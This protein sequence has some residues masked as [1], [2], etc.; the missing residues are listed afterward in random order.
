[1]ALIGD[2]KHILRKTVTKGQ[3]FQEGKP[4]VWNGGIKFSAT[5]HVQENE[6][7]L[8]MMWKSTRQILLCMWSTW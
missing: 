3:K 8:E 4:G 1:M 6:V 5:N 2:I 7:L